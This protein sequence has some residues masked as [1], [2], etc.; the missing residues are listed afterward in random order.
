M[1]DKVCKKMR[2]EGSSL[3]SPS[4]ADR[5]AREIQRLI[6]N[7]RYYDYSDVVPDSSLRCIIPAGVPLDNS[8]EAVLNA[9]L[10][11]YLQPIFVAN[12]SC[13]VNS[14]KIG[15]LPAHPGTNITK[16]NRM[17][18]FFGCPSWFYEKKSCYNAASDT[19]V[20]LWAKN[21]V[22]FGAVPWDIREGLDVTC[23]TKKIYGSGGLGELLD[24]LARIG[25]GHCQHEEIRGLFIW[26]SGF[27]LVV[28]INGA[29]TEI[30]KCNWDTAGSHVLLSKFIGRKK[31]MWRRGLDKLC[32]GHNFTL[33]PTGAYLGKGGS[34][35]VFQVTTNAD[36]KCALKIV[37]ADYAENVRKEVDV[38]ASHREVLGASDHIVSLNSTNLY[39]VSDIMDEA[40]TAVPV[41]VVGYLMN[42]IGTAAPRGTAAERYAIFCSLVALH[43]LNIVHGDARV[44][45]IILV[46][47]KLKWID[48]MSSHITSS[49]VEFKTDAI[50]LLKSIY[51]RDSLRPEVL[52]MLDTYASNVAICPSV[53]QFHTAE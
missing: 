38:I 3:I 16:C 2:I 42:S 26:N 51:G 23:E 44:V 49:S 27:M 1:A 5:G 33:H 21:D 10:Y 9:T 11:H 19:L 41:P 45:N 14:E 31:C 48:F 39:S 22:K 34:G 28:V 53:E 6:A 18:D 20:E 15:W 13:L 25:T 43:R 35:Y 17:P 52:N 29:A 24:Y 50:S 4:P 32:M 47:G 12:G 46:D 30:T 8:T 7:G 36:E 40:S 37:I